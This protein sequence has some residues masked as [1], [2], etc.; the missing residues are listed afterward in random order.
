MVS[1]GVETSLLL[2]MHYSHQD[3]CFLKKKNFSNQKSGR[4]KK[5]QKVGFGIHPVGF[6]NFHNKYF[7]QYSILI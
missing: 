5:A 4:K 1:R 2:W 7:V 6:L 3:P